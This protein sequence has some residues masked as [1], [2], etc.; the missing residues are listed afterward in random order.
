MLR[1]KQFYRKSV[2]ALL[3]EIKYHRKHGDRR[4]VKHL[5]CVLWD[6]RT[7][8]QQVIKVERLENKKRGRNGRR[9]HK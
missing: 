1:A 9:N 3:D 7:H 5:Q 4:A 2:R 6:L 8:W